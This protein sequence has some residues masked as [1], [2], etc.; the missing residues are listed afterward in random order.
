M[1]S[2]RAERT[3]HLLRQ[4]WPERFERAEID[5]RGRFQ[6]AG[7]QFRVIH[8]RG[9]T[10]FAPRVDRRRKGAAD[11]AAHD[12]RA[13]GPQLRQRPRDIFSREPAILP[14]GDCVLRSKAEWARIRH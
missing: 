7:W 6:I 8:F 3:I 14:I 10:L 4:N 5:L 13:R 11:I 9:E 2:S 1:S 12:L